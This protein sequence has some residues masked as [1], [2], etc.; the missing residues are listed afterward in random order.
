[1][2]FSW[3]LQVLYLI[4]LFLVICAILLVAGPTDCEITAFFGQLRRENLVATKIIK[5]ITDWTGPLLIAGY[6]LF[7][8]KSLVTKN[9]DGLRFV[10][11]FAVEQYGLFLLVIHI[12]KFCVGSP[13]P[14]AGEILR[15][16]FSTQ[17]VHHSFP[18]GHTYETTGLC[19]PL[20]H[21]HGGF[22]ALVIGLIPAVMGFTRIYLGQ[23]HLVD[24]A[25]GA[26]FASAATFFTLRLFAC[27]GALQGARAKAA[28]SRQRGERASWK[29]L[30]IIFTGKIH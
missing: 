19:A 29:I 25:A 17:N 11:S 26:L 22:K 7:A 16:H 27:L 15:Q 10:L 28:A 8:L 24:V 1:M 13:R 14:Y 9:R 5:G 18:S 6:C 12:L 21:L 3:R 23:H 30:Q 20:A 2:H 4:P